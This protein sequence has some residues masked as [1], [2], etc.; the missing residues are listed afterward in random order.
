THTGR[1]T[2]RTKTNP[3]HLTS[4][5][6]VTSPSTITS[7]TGQRVLRWDAPDGTGPNRRS[8]A[9]RAEATPGHALPGALGGGS[10]AASP[11]K[12]VDDFVLTVVRKDGVQGCRS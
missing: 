1:V 3:A 8:D 11:Y 10:T 2:H 4:L 12:E 5:A 7:Y 9:R 6:H